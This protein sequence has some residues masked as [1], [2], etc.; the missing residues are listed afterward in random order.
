VPT[1]AVITIGDTVIT[2]GFSLIFPEGIMIGTVRDISMDEGDNF[3]T[4]GIDFS[5]DYNRLD[6]V[7]IIKNFHKEEM[8]WLLKATG[9]G[10][11]P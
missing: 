10:E 4:I 11:T 8:D 1:H 7:Y 5:V 6:N 2:S 9:I 3:Y